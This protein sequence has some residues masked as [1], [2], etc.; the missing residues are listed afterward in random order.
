M[1]IPFSEQYDPKALT[2]CWQ[3]QSSSWPKQLLSSWVQLNLQ[4]P[5]YTIQTIKL[6]NHGS[7]H[8]KERTLIHK[9]HFYQMDF[10]ISDTKVETLTKVPI[11]TY[12][13]KEKTK[14]EA[15]FCSMFLENFNTWGPTNL[16]LNMNHNHIASLH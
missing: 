14:K 8:K 5:K 7:F 11:F 4:V 15:I 12:N 1:A 10:T 9:S 6:L 2:L 16:P 13:L 3:N